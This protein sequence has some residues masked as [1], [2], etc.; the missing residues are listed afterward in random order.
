MPINLASPGIEVK[1]VD[2]T[3]GR[4]QT[5]TTKT[6]AIVGAFAKGPVG[7]PTLVENEQDLIDVFGE[8]SATGKQF[9]DWMVASSYLSYGGVLSVVRAD[10]DDLFNAYCGVGT[11]G[12]RK[13]IKSI[14][15]Y[16]NN[17]VNL[18]LKNNP[19]INF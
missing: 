16:N 19:E 8:P 14:E 5:A 1:E 12:D 3:I 10:D 7:Q 11:V 18:E 9:E 6:A 13:K 17:F 4:V 15:D 2:L